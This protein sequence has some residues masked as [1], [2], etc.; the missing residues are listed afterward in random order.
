MT[1][2]SP[3]TEPV[4]SAVSATERNLPAAR[5]VSAA[6]SSGTHAD[7]NAQPQLTERSTA[8]ADYA[9]L[10]ADIADVVARLDPP[11]A[12]GADLAAKADQDLMAL[13]PP[14]VIVLPLPRPIRT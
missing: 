11:R 2:F 6:V 14:P 7:A 3:R 10:Q 5:G 12:N 4:A 13:M 8:T 9:R 1:E